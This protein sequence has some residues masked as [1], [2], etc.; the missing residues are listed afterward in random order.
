MTQTDH[1]GLFTGAIEQFE[2]LV[3]GTAGVEQTTQTLDKVVKHGSRLWNQRGIPAPS[4][5]VVHTPSRGADPV[6]G[7]L[8]ATDYA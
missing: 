8:R 3:Q 5:T 2:D 4:R 7:K 1:W 6:C